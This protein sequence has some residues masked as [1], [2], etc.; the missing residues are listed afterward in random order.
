MNKNLYSNNLEQYF[1][2]IEE[3]IFQFY[4]SIKTQNNCPQNNTN[5]ADQGIPGKNYEFTIYRKD[6]PNI[7]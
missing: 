6:L 2:E 1:T 4:F 3:K 7:V 5:L